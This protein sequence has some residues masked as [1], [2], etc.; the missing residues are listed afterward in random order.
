MP[1]YYFSMNS[2]YLIYWRRKNNFCWRNLEDICGWIH[3]VQLHSYR[4]SNDSASQVHPIVPIILQQLVQRQIEKLFRQNCFADYSTRLNWAYLL[5]TTFLY[6][7]FSSVER[8]DWSIHSMALCRLLFIR[9]NTLCVCLSVNPSP[10][11]NFSKCSFFNFFFLPSSVMASS[12]VS[13]GLTIV[14]IDKIWSRILECPFCA[15][16]CYK[17][18][19]FAFS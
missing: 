13:S 11:A 6:A 12:S 5:W 2:Y 7:V 17:M 14:N 16:E 19:C 18:L 4:N 3:P 8:N 9:L 15:Q 1:D 10:L